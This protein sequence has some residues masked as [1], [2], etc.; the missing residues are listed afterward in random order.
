MSRPVRFSGH[1]ERAKR[2][3]A[4]AGVVLV[5]PMI[6]TTS[7][8]EPQRVSPLRVFGSAAIL[9]IAEIYRALCGRRLLKPGKM[10]T[11]HSQ[12]H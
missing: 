4:Q 11:A 1:H 6:V 9:G 7:N 12:W 5:A 10:F 2:A 3:F 8:S